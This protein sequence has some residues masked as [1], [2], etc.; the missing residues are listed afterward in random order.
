MSWW[1]LKFVC[2]E[3]KR[4]KYSVNKRVVYN[5]IGICCSQLQGIEL[6]CGI[7]K[8]GAK[9]ESTNYF[10]G[11]FWF[12]LWVQVDVKKEVAKAISPWFQEHCLS[13]K[14]KGVE[15]A[16][17]FMWLSVFR[18]CFAPKIIRS[19]FRRIVCLKPSTIKVHWKS[20][21]RD[22]T[23]D[24]K[25]VR[26]KLS[27]AINVIYQW[28]RKTVTYTNCICKLMPFF[29]TSKLNKVIEWNW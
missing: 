27:G 25:Y 22:M 23:I 18:G 20:A 4:K 24:S 28:W 17:S 13:R 9:R 7:K 6:F 2:R 21:L 3:R 5:F 16:N 29:V 8:F 19:F 12:Q 26:E 1:G 11:N 15:M 14:K 10:R